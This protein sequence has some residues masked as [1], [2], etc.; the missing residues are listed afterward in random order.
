MEPGVGSKGELDNHELNLEDL[1]DAK[2]QQ[3]RREEPKNGKT[4]NNL[5]LFDRLTARAAAAHSECGTVRAGY[6]V[7]AALA[8]KQA[9]ARPQPK[10]ITGLGLTFTIRDAVLRLNC[11]WTERG[12]IENV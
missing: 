2:M 12:D 5:G 10:A 9:L 3:S 8:S 4:E 6:G 7:A 1:E 11:P